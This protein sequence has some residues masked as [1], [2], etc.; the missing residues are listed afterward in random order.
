M[1]SSSRQQHTSLFT[2]LIRGAANRI[3]ADPN[4]PAQSRAALAA[5]AE[6]VIWQQ[7]RDI[8]GSDRVRLRAPDVEPS[9]RQTRASRIEGAIANGEPIAAIAQRER[10]DYH[11]VYARARRRRTVKT[12]RIGP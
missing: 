5:A 1:S 12:E 6:H 7:W 2:Q 11:A 10:L 8:F 4:V 3:A 9:V